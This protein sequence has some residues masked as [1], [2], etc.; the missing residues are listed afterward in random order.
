MNRVFYSKPDVSAERREFY[1]RLDQSSAA[2]L[3]EVLADIVRTEPRT[4]C[5][6]ALW[7]YEEIRPLVMESGQIITAKEAERRVLI[8]EN[9]GLR[10]QSRITQSIYA[11]L[12]LV[13]PGE[14]APSH[15]HT[16]SALR[17]IIE[18]DGA[19]TAVDGERFTMHPGDFILTPSWTYHDHGNPS[20][21]PVVWLDGLDIPTVNHFDTS[22][23]EHY[24]E[25]T[26]PVS[27]TDGDALARY[28]A[29][30]L[31]LE[32]TPIK[33]S[34]LLSYPYERSR[35]AL[36]RLH[37][38]GPVHPG[39]GIKMQYVN[40]ATGGYPLPTIGA[41]I[42]LL[43]AGFHGAPYRATDATVYCCVEGQGRCQIG[44]RSLDWKQHD[45]FVAPSWTSVSL[46]AQRESVLFSFSDRPAQ[47]ALGIWREENPM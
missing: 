26:Q 31:P 34:P 7:R 35:K 30:L 2:P 12:Q 13:L 6:P 37:R 41:F 22:F 29:N 10:G 8:L 21:Q 15:R 14:L 25:D 47:K 28:G 44:G 20:Q 45:I 43:P 33:R 39:H 24:P 27:R 18:G 38:N 42:Q 36:E 16:A 9:P 4:A 17:F 23:A 3:W 11:G 40:P 5:Q 46:E 32:Y 1:G 19:Y